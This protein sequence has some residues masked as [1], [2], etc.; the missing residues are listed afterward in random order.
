MTRIQGPKVL[1]GTVALALVALWLA[2]ST[3]RGAGRV[4]GAR[5]ARATTEVDLPPVAESTEAPLSEVDGTPTADRWEQL[6][7]L[8]A[9]SAPFEVERRPADRRYQLPD[10]STAA[11]V[12][13]PVPTRAEPERVP[14]LRLLGTVAASGSG[15]AVIQLDALPPRVV[16]LGDEW[17][18]YRVSHIQPGAVVLS[19]AGSELRLAVEDAVRTSSSALETLSGNRLQR[20]LLAYAENIQRQLREGEGI[21]VVQPA[22]DVGPVLLTDANGVSTGIMELPERAP[23][24]V[25]QPPRP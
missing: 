22:L 15:V 20:G 6:L 11:D 5:P 7:R 12:P 16:A 23:L 9:A 24:D 10:D 8:A 21:G 4:S 1:L 17:L 14:G 25:A 18:G 13:P 3:G 19:K 2:T